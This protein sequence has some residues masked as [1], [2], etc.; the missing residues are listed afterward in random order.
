MH[1][2]GARGM[3][4][5]VDWTYGQLRGRSRRGK[6]ISMNSQRAAAAAASSSDLGGRKRETLE[7]IHLLPQVPK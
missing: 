1:K 3:V 5:P 6:E 4:H 7:W 2:L